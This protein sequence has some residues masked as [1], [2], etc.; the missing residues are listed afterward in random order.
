M[1]RF[2]SRPRRTP[3]RT[4]TQFQRLLSLCNS[5]NSNIGVVMLE[6]KLW[7]VILNLVFLLPGAHTRSLVIQSLSYSA[8]RKSL[9]SECGWFISKSQSH[10]RNGSKHLVSPILHGCHLLLKNNM[11]AIIENNQVYRW[12]FHP[13]WTTPFV[14]KLRWPIDIMTIFFF[15]WHLI[16]LL[17]TNWSFSRDKPFCPRQILIL[18]KKPFCSWQNFTLCGLHSVGVWVH[19]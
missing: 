14:E 5:N 6:L 3:E 16:K 17:M 18:V 13:G 15:S 9:R 2:R 1:R 19:S 8:F 10:A 12:H 4:N 11:A 7:Y